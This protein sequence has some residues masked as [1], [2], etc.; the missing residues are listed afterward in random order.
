MRTR[1]VASS[2]RAASNATLWPRGCTQ[3]ALPVVGGEPSFAASVNGMCAHRR[4]YRAALT[5]QCCAAAARLA[6]RMSESSAVSGKAARAVAEKE[7][8]VAHGRRA[9]SRTCKHAKERS[10]K[11]TRFDGHV[12]QVAPGFRAPQRERTIA[13]QG[14]A[15]KAERHRAARAAA[16]VAEKQPTH[17]KASSPPQWL[18]AEAQ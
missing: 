4:T 5:R 6:H 12:G 10:P 11:A 1:V 17:E 9:S 14:V 18:H 16:Y 15:R 8:T 7:A 13:T 3:S 2:R